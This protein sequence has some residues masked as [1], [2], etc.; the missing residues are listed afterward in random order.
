MNTVDMAQK[1]IAYGKK[2]YA[3]NHQDNRL[4]QD[5]G[6]RMLALQDKIDALMT[7]IADKDEKICMLES[8]KTIL[9]ERIAIMLEDEADE[10]PPFEPLDAAAPGEAAEDFW[11]DDWPLGDQ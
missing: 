1:L 2:G 3:L 7:E 4:M 11:D 9:E 6:K 10:D 5:A 8:E